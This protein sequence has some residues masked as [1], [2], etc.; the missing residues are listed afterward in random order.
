MVVDQF[1]EKYC[2]DIINLAKG[3][4]TFVTDSLLEA[5]EEAYKVVNKS[6]T[7]HFTILTKFIGDQVF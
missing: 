7:F 1:D 6:L 2:K 4:E 5:G 3:A